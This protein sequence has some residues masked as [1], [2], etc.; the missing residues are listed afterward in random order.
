MT[1]EELR[2]RLGELNRRGGPAVEY[3]TIG[4]LNFVEDT[5]SLSADHPEKSLRVLVYSREHSYCIVARSG[6]QGRNDYL[7]CT[8]SNRAPWA[9]EDHTRGSDLA[10]GDLSEKTWLRILTDIVACE[11]VLVTDKAKLE[12]MAE[13]ENLSDCV[14]EDKT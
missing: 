7:G 14:G 11:L 9:G 1:I 12:K 2:E 4:K 13:I 5:S 3:A 8:M 10:D 6:R